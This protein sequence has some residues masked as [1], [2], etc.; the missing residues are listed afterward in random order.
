MNESLLA[1]RNALSLVGV[2]QNSE[3]KTANV[4]PTSKTR[5]AIDLL[6]DSSPEKMLDHQVNLREVASGLFNWSGKTRT[7]KSVIR[8]LNVALTTPGKYHHAVELSAYI[9]ALS[10]M[11]EPDRIARLFTALNE[12]ETAYSPAR[13]TL[14]LSHKLS[15][16]LSE[17]N[18]DR[19]E[20]LAY[21]LWVEAHKGRWWDLTAGEQQ[22]APA[23]DE[24]EPAKEELMPRK[25]LIEL[26]TNF[27][28]PWNTSNVYQISK[29]PENE[30][31]REALQNYNNSLLKGKIVD[32]DIALLA[33]YIP[34]LEIDERPESPIGSLLDNL[35]MLKNE[36]DFDFPE[37]PKSF[38]ALF[39]NI[40]FYGGANFPFPNSILVNDG[41]NLTKDAKLEVVKTATDLAA[42]RTYMGNCTWS[43]K[44]R[45][46][47]GH[48]VLF[49][50]HHNGEIY[51]G[52]LTLNNNRWRLGEINS[53]FNRGQV[54]NEIR[55]AFTA[56]I[57]KLPPL[58][59]DNEMTKRIED[60]NRLK[61]LKAKKYRYS[62]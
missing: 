59:A 5:S 53:R 25:E 26:F 12:V 38:A 11:M 54:P 3:H 29:L 55:S 51:N 46:E 18:E 8:A 44:S 19:R 33:S 47:Q 13:Y 2:E 9:S 24:A 23:V 60:Y 43:Y 7:T 31:I 17:F 52:S 1:I 20:R 41:K 42:N 14:Q 21:S 15:K 45:M 34:W 61:S 50:V 16:I 58:Q 35:I 56:F 27:K 49:R 10:P 62:I 39:P 22:E 40:T 30:E 28:L 57:G 6:A 4:V 37:K 36:I 32:P 48:Y